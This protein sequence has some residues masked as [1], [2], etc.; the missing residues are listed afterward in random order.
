VCQCSAPQVERYLNKISGPLI[1][2][3]DIH[4]EVSAVPFKELS[5]QRGGTSS[6]ELRSQVVNARLRQIDRF[7]KAC[8]DCTHPAPSLT[9]NANMS[10]RD[11]RGFCRPEPDGLAFLQTAV[12]ELGLSAR[13]H[14]KVL[15]VS[16]TIADLEDS[17]TIESQHMSEAIS[18]RVLDR[19]LMVT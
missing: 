13:A 19:G 1:D 14:D 11:V 9:C 17:D 5:D 15:R 3:I 4:L 8:S 12:S 10:S 7:H 6:T 18:Y 16:R 2:R